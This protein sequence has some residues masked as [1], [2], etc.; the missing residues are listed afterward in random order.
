MG[1]L[2]Y[3]SSHAEHTTPHSG[4][5]RGAPQWYLSICTP[6]KWNMQGCPTVVLVSMH[7]R[8]EICRGAPQWYSSICTP[9][10][11][12]CKG[13]PQW[14]L[15]ICTPHSGICRVTPQW[16]SCVCTPHKWNMQGCLTMIPISM[17]S[18]QM[19]YIEV[20]HSGTR[21]YALP[22]VEYAGVPHNGTRLY[23]LPT[24]EYSMQGYHTEELISMHSARWGM[25]GY[26]T[27]VLVPMY[28]LPTVEYARLPQSVTRLY[29]RPQWA[30][31]DQRD[32]MGKPEYRSGSSC[33]IWVMKFG[34]V[35]MLNKRWSWQ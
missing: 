4:I 3:L 9:H 12:I 19:E 8:S 10:S 24:V 21:F 15:S 7:S 31:T 27:V 16:Y 20:S 14:Y 30:E 23:A 25:Q 1:R 11:R 13:T 22:T 28:A 2:L 18:S 33:V 35:Q 26:H 32:A 34:W 5:C 6:R 29:A 17:H